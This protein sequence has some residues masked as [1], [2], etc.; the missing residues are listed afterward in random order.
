MVENKLREKERNDDRESVAVLY[1]DRFD[2]IWILEFEAPIGMIDLSRRSMLRPKSKERDG[3][4]QEN[5]EICKTARSQLSISYAASS[6]P[7]QRL[8]WLANCKVANLAAR[9]PKV[10]RAARDL[11]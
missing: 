6:H 1:I 2:T 10:H 3:W 4:L 11:G 9:G 7:C 8:V 5:I